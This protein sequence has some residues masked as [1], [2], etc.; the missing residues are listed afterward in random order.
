M[1]ITTALFSQNNESGDLVKKSFAKYFELPRE[2]TYLHLNK[3]TYIVNENI[4]FKGYVY[5]RQ[6]GK[7]FPE[8]TNIYVG[9][10]DSIG[11]PVKTSLYL[12]E[13]GVFKGHLEVD[14]TF[15]SGNYY[16]KAFT[17]W[18]KNFKEKDA[19]VQKIKILNQKPIRTQSVP[20]KYDIQLLPEGGNL[21]AD[22]PNVVGV[23][24]TNQFGYG[25]PE[26]NI[27]VF[28]D[29]EAQVAQLKVSKFGHGKF[30]FT[31]NPERS[32][33]AIVYFLDGTEKKVL[34]PKAQRYGVN[35]SVKNIDQQRVI[36]S[37]TTNPET[38]QTLGDGFFNL[39]IHRDGLAKRI[40]LSFPKDALFVSRIIEKKILL[41]GMNVFTL[42]D[43]EEKPVLERLFFNSFEMEKGKVQIIKLKEEKDSLT[44][45]VKVH[46]LESK[47]Q[48]LSISV[49]PKSTLSYNHKDNILS[50][51]HLKPYV[52]GFIENAQYY[53]QDLDQRKEV[54]LDLLLM[55]QGWS[56]YEWKR[57]MKYPPNQ[58]FKFE[59][60]LS[61]TGTLN[62]KTSPKDKLF[63]RMPDK[64]SSVLDITDNH[65][66]FSNYYPFKGAK[67]GF[68]L[69][70]N[71]QKLTKP[72]INIGSFMTD[73]KDSIRNLW[74]ENSAQLI[75]FNPNMKFSS[76]FFLSDDT[77]QLDEVTVVENKKSEVAEK[78]VFIP[79]YLKGKVTE[80]TENLEFQF[81]YVLDII[82]SK[83]YEVREGLV[84]GSTERVIIRVRTVQSFGG[85]NAT[86]PD[87]IFP[88]PI[89]YLNDVRLSNFDQ[90]HELP[91]GEIEAYHIDRTGAGEGIRGAGGVIRIYTRRGGTKAKSIFEEIPEK[92]VF[93][94]T[95]TEGFQRPKKFYTPRYD[96]Y[97]SDSFESFGVIHWV[98]ELLTDENGIG[99]FKIVNTGLENISF[100]IEGMG[101]DG[102][103]LSSRKSLDLD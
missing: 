32:Y 101:A 83:G 59:N 76:G 43:S 26:S 87:R 69:V 10:Y 52:K 82:R 23:K 99:S 70:R 28:D 97:D 64:T 60:G 50:T 4:W 24:I 30:N 36:V 20:V 8:T 21:I 67:V 5:N 100:F 80:V 55:L 85:V 61:V 45:Q 94:H 11:K 89:I 48:N 27:V 40:G 17:N 25:V 13:E 54:E 51:F 37:L 103:L 96:A 65:F 39:L 1:L 19:H 77:I 29:Q 68:S 31:P 15:V 38:R 33:S 35:I 9:I 74:Q 42:F 62:N 53:F 88:K 93:T 91:T 79:K 81:P 98:P 22:T 16:I 63:L 18:M 49:L 44:I 84:W 41:R 14:S 86:D 90:L 66:E 57:I 75:E 72:N 12:A 71:N 73:V 102:S 3:S 58:F 47:L 78:N 46:N 2:A 34:L 7:A 6:I 56:S 95:F 92:Q